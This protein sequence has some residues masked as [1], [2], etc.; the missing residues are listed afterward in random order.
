MKACLK[1]LERDD[2]V[3]SLGFR[4]TQSW[5]CAA[6]W[7]ATQPRSVSD[8]LNRSVALPA[9]NQTVQAISA[10]FSLWA[11]KFPPAC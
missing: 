8:K 6:R 9:H 10:A 3:P 5:P 11:D 4:G 1:I 2:I 7:S